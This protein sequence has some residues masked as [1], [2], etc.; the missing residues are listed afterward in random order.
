MQV[1]KWIEILT[2]L[3]LRRILQHARAYKLKGRDV[4]FSGPSRAQMDVHQAHTH[5]PR[6]TRVLLISLCRY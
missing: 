3:A 5:R 1:P 6:G 4:V 2:C